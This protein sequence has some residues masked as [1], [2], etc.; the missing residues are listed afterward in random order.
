MFK[1][2]A[3]VVALGVDTFEHDPIS[4]FKLASEDYLS[5]GQRLAQLGTGDFLFDAPGFFEV[6]LMPQIYNARRFGYDFSGAP[7]TTR[8]EAA[9]LALDEVQRAHPDNQNDTPEGEKTQ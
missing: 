5:L 2:D 1:P 7:H 4:F 6:V 3:L 9:C 8:I